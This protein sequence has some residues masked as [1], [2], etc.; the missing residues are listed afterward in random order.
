MRKKRGAICSALAPAS[1]AA[2]EEKEYDFDSPK[3]KELV[4]FLEKDLV[5][6]FDEQ[7][8]DKSMYDKKVEFKDPITKY[9]SLDGYLFN[10]QMLRRVLTPKFE[11]HSVTQVC[12]P[13]PPLYR[14]ALP[15]P[16]LCYSKLELF[17]RAAV[18]G[19][20]VDTPPQQCFSPRH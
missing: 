18:T 11:L 8:I 9:E 20:N 7:G 15:W 19:L 16:L 4:A 6:L 12:Y 2:A 3:M 1:S 14:S 13:K 5:H 17:C 10:I